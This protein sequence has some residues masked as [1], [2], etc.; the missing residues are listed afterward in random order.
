MFHVTTSG[1]TAGL[2]AAQVTAIETT[3]LAAANYWGRYLDFTRASI[4][5]EIEFESLGSSVLGNA[6][7]VL[8]Y[9]GTQ[10]GLDI[11]EAGTIQE[12]RTGNDPNGSRPDIFVTL[13]I[14]AFTDGTFFIGDFSN[15]NFPSLPSGRID[16][17]STMVHELAHGFGFLSFLD[18]NNNDRSN[19]DLFVDELNGQFFFDGAEARVANGGPVRLTNGD[20]SHIHPDIESIL[21]PVITYGRRI[22]P[23][24]V[25]VAIFDDIGFD[26]FGPTSGNDTV[27]GFESVDSENLLGGDDLFFALGG[28]D[29]VSGGAGNDTLNGE[30]GNDRLLG[31]AQHDDL[32]GG[33]GNDTI[34]GG[35]QGDRLTGGFGNDFLYG[36]R[37]NDILLGRASFDWLE[38]GEGNDRLEGEA[39]ADNLFGGTGHDTLNGGD[40]LD[41]LFGDTGNDVV[42]GGAGND[43]IRGGAGFDTIMGGAG[44]DRLY[45][46]FNWDIF[47]FEDGFGNDIIKDFNVPNR[48]EKIDLSGVSSITDFSDLMNNHLSTIAGNA[49]ITDGSNTITLEGVNAAALTDN[50]FIF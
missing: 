35:D 23:N 41:R 29:M 7:P 43:A 44:D 8:F 39:N 40:G 10:N 37:G 48:Y 11:F 30:D 38:G 22:L 27:Y 36:E 19:F 15:G 3:T 12:A 24:P 9:I 31:G 21:G 47:V 16:L 2:T 18:R 45:G 25:D 49:V 50:D 46:N 34:F 14:D 1:S 33:T 42:N 20:P 4:E 13:N 5:I 17:F 26:V 6:G 28:D 32:F